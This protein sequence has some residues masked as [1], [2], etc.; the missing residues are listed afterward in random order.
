MWSVLYGPVQFSATENV[1]FLSWPARSTDIS[2]I[3][4][5]WSMVAERLDRHH[6]P[7]TMVDELLYRVQSAWAYVHD[8]Q[9]LFDS[10]PRRIS[11][12]T[13]ARGDC[14]EY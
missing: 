11:A 1:Q 2:P 4:N 14:S 8:I 12:I 10:M 6:T 3:E 5:I 9:S 13:T 7:V